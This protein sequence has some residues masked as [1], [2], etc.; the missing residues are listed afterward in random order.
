MQALLWG[1]G[2]VLVIFIPFVISDAIKCNYYG[3]PMPVANTITGS[4]TVLAQGTYDGEAYA[5]LKRDADEEIFCVNVT[6]LKQEM[7][8]VGGTIKL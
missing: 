7:M 3:I 8:K 1:L 4:Y 2:V 5:I 6:P